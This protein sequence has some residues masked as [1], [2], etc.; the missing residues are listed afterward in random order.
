MKIIISGPTGAIG[1]ALISKY[2]ENGD[3]V[4]AICRKG[5]A[6]KIMLPVSSRF[7]ILE[8]NLAD[9]SN[10]QISDLFKE[11]YDC[12]YHLAWDGTVGFDRQDTEKQTR[13]IFYSLDAVNLAHRFGCDIFIGAGSQ[14]EYGRV[15]G[16]LKPDTPVNPDNGYG[17]AKLC[18]GQMTRLLCG[19]LGMKHIWVR[20][21]S[22]YGPY[23]GEKSMIISSL[24]KMLNEEET[25]FTKGEQKWDFLYCDDAANAIYLLANKGIDK[26]TYVLGSG[27]ALMLSDYIEIMTGI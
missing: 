23:D 17:I 6:R 8:L 5:S 16:K 10:Y 27:K 4:L 15:E 22:V 14:A 7:K 13:N 26:K 12:F 9:Y 2:I 21:L 24:R 25:L 11:K 3:D 18:S 19:Q 1:R 20:I